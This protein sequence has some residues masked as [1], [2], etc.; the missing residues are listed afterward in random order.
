MA[1]ITSSSEMIAGISI[2]IIYPFFI[3]KF[4]NKVSGYNEAYEKCH[5]SYTISTN[6]T[7]DV[8]GPEFSDARIQADKDKNDACKKLKEVELKKHILLLVIGVATVVG[9]TFIQTRSTKL[10]VGFG[11]IF[12]ILTA[13]TLYWNKYGEDQKLIVL[14]ISLLI[15]VVTS[16]RLYKIKDAADIFN[17]FNM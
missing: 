10:G 3:N 8:E 14:A 6:A 9:S 11:G 4:I 7:I 5:P 13:L 2:A 12:T 16:V 1:D 17:V 15:V